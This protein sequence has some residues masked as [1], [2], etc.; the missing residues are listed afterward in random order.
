MCDDRGK[1]SVFVPALRANARG[2]SW[3][4][5]PTPGKAVS[6]DDFYIAQPSTA[7]AGKLNAALAA[8]KNLLFTPGVY[9]LD[10]TLRVSKAEHHPVRPGR[11]FARPHHRPTLDYG[12]RR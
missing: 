1:F 5:G 6:L 4:N 8:G 7:D 2:V 3:A 11:S 10:D 12:R 9:K